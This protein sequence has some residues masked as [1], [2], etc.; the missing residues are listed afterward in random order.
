MLPPSREALFGWAKADRLALPPILRQLVIVSQEA[1]AAR[2]RLTEA[3][4]RS[5]PSLKNHKA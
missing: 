3:W 1:V 2:F 5:V 4:S